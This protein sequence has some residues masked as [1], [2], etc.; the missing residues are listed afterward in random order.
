MDNGTPC[1]QDVLKSEARAAKDRK[2]NES[3]SASSET[4]TIITSNDAL[5]GTNG[6][7][8]NPTSIDLRQPRLITGG[9]L[10]SYQLAGLE[11]LVSLYENGLNGILAD[12]MGLGKTLQVISLLAFLVDMGVKGPFLIV[13]PLSI[14]QNWINEINKFAPEIKVLKYYG[15]PLEREDMRINLL[16]KMYNADVVAN[17]KRGKP[18]QNDESNNI[19]VVVSSYDIIMNDSK[20]L[21]NYEWKYLIIDEGHRLKN[22][23][24]RLIKELKKFHTANRLLLTG[25]PL[26]NN[27]SELWSLLNFLL[28]DIFHDL[29]LFQSWFDFDKSSTSAGSRDYDKELG[30]RANTIELVNSLHEILKPFLLRR[31]K[32]DVDQFLPDKRE[33][34]IYTTM[35]KDQVELSQSI[36]NHSVREFVTQKIKEIISA[37]HLKLVQSR[38]HD[39]RALRS[40]SRKTDKVKK[41]KLAEN[42]PEKVRL[43]LGRKTVLYQESDAEDDDD[44]EDDDFINR[45]EKVIKDQDVNSNNELFLGED[46]NERSEKIAKSLVKSKGLQNMVMQ[47]RLCC[48][49]PHLFYYPWSAS[50]L[51]EEQYLH[52]L[53]HEDSYE[54]VD[55][56]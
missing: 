30:G 27:L 47:L 39:G 14:V 6:P 33:Y 24:C 11:W 22:M 25:T 54:L 50:Y 40:S 46:D 34:I 19:S 9:I 20:F 12:E 42:S 21:Q 18:T 4:S 28:P 7:L 51:S 10:H 17:K 32:T 5:K 35:T 45:L 1:T 2:N 43:R 49:T 41:L 37:N 36:I 16:D 15:T 48:N 53:D 23:N 8:L 13:S 29:E 26:Q 3:L 55:R 52:Q 38:S 44:L 56:R 31:V